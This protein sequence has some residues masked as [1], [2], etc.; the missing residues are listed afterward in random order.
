MSIRFAKYG[1]HWRTALRRDYPLRYE[2]LTYSGVRCLRDDSLIF[3]R[4][5]TAI[6]GSNGVGKSTLAHAIAE[7]IAGE[8]STQLLREA[9]AR[10]EGS[11]LVANLAT[12]E[13][14][15]ELSF[16]Y[17]GG[18]RVANDSIASDSFLW[19]EP[20]IMAMLCQRQINQDPE[21]Q[22]ILDGLGPFEMLG[23]DIEAAKYVV[24]KDYATLAVYEINDYGPFEVWPYFEVTCDGI[25]YTSEGMGRGELS[26]LTAFWGIHRAKRNSIIIL[27]EPETFTSCRS[28]QALMDH[29]AMW[30]ATKECLIKVG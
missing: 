22:D 19:L 21:F 24:G 12:E 1:D 13:G 4:G 26:L 6:V 9:V 16:Q 2:R 20:S 29:I 3:S 23:D 25:T 11:N 27:E 30:C 17:I 18:E 14:V 15:H 10:L 8:Q 7:A 5:I 28:Q